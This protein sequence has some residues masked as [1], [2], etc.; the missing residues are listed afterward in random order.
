MLPQRTKGVK[1]TDTKGCITII[2]YCSQNGRQIRLHPST[3]SGRTGW[4]CKRERLT[5]RAEPVEARTPLDAR[6]ARILICTRHESGNLHHY[7][8]VETAPYI[9]SVPSN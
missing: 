2:W 4:G 5:V 9:F 7:L 3:S 6:R 8:S 1:V